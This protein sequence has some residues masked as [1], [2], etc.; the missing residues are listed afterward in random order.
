MEI[1]LNVAK[2]RLLPCAG[3]IFCSFLFVIVGWICGAGIGYL[4]LA[5]GWVE[6]SN[7]MFSGMTFLVFPFVGGI[8]ALIAM[9]I[10]RFLCWTKLQHKYMKEYEGWTW[11]HTMGIIFLDETIWMVAFVTICVLFV[12]VL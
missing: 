11:K 10:V 1:F 4:S 7:E 3:W 5:M 6:F 8:I 9:H 12:T 2:Q